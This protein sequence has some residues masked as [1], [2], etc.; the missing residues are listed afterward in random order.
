MIR[1]KYKDKGKYI[2]Y[3]VVDEIRTLHKS[4]NNK[5]NTKKG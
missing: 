3:K 5:R 2:I 4:Q 1:N